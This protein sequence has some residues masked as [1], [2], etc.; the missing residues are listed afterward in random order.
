[1]AEQR[2][3]RVAYAIEGRAYWD[4]GF[5]VGMKARNRPW[6][7]SKVI[8]TPDGVQGLLRDS[9]SRAHCHPGRHQAR[10]SQAGT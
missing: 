6:L 1:M 2:A 7:L 9:G 10:L 3:V 8:G 5:D 4:L